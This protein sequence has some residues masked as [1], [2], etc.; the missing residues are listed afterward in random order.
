MGRCVMK[1]IFFRIWFDKY[2]LNI[3][4]MSHR[5][6]IGIYRIRRGDD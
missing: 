3:R 4:T 5:V 6:I 2:A 1:K